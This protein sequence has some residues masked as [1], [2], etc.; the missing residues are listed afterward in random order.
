MRL[1]HNWHRYPRGAGARAG[2]GGSL[3]GVLAVLWWG[4]AFALVCGG[5]SNWVTMD[6]KEKCFRNNPGNFT[7]TPRI[8]PALQKS[9]FDTPSLHVPKSEISQKCS[10]LSFFYIILW[11]KT[12]NR[13]QGGAIEKTSINQTLHCDFTMRWQQWLG[14]VNGRKEEQYPE[15]Q[16][17]HCP[18]WGDALLSHVVSCRALT[19]K[20]SLT[21][22]DQC[23][24]EW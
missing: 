8:I 24:V 12:A 2:R 20:T 4:R 17:H 1:L 23:L 6:K 19:T 16:P 11:M 21:K 9:C 10:S 7:P 5:P 13:K 15:I 14:L 22:Y 18:R 3:N